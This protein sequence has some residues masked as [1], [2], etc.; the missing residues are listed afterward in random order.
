MGHYYSEL[1]DSQQA[2]VGGKQI[3][4]VDEGKLSTTV[5]DKLV[6]LESKLEKQAKEIKKLKQRLND[7]DNEER[8]LY[9]H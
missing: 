9:E 5:E 3:T 2:Q 4:K 6:E 1:S 8:S 7:K